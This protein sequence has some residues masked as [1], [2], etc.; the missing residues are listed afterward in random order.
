MNPTYQLKDQGAIGAKQ[1][2]TTRDTKQPETRNKLNT[3]LKSKAA[4]QAPSSS[5]EASDCKHFDTGK[6]SQFRCAENMRTEREGKRKRGA[7][8]TE[9]LLRVPTR[10]GKPGKMGRHFPV[11]EF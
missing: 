8:V 11:R 4:T 5:K 7:L 1:R 2:K 6:N 9:E 10:T 3:I